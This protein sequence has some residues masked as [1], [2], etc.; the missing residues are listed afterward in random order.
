[1]KKAIIDG[2]ATLWA[3][4]TIESEIFLNKPAEWFK[5]WFYLVNRV[6]FKNE[7]NYK[8]GELF[9]KYEWIS[10]ATKA[11]KNQIDGFIRWAKV[12]D[13]LTT[14]K[15]TRG[16]IVKIANYSKYQT[17]DNYYYNVKTDTE[18]EFQPKQNRNRNDTILKN[19]KNE[20]NDIYIA[21]R[22]AG[23]Q[24]NELLKEFEP[25]NPTINYGNKTQRKALEEMLKK[26]GYEKLLNTIKFAIS[27]QGEKYAPTIT[28]PIQLKNKLG[29]LLVYYK[30]ETDNPIIINL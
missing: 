16:F 1:M 21:D 2:G 10:D 27:K 25:I 18:N 11:S 26:F 15:T 5:I 17:L 24:I 19:E 3:R 20:K 28:T 23:K 13:M 6:C 9:L 30:K 14:Q 4:Q 29:E 8:R 7:K 12:A 22:S